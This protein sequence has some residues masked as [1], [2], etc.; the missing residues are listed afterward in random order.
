MVAFARWWWSIDA[1][2][3]ATRPMPSPKTIGRRGCGR[4][5]HVDGYVERVHV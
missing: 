5:V 3:W 4:R 1:L 2:V